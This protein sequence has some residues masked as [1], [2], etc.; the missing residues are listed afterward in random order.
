MLTMD[1]T[2]DTANPAAARARRLRAAA[3][4]HNKMAVQ[5]SDRSLKFFGASV[6]VFALACVLIKNESMMV[7]AAAS[8]IGSGV[9]FVLT[10]LN[11]HYSVW[12]SDEARNA[13]RKAVFAYDDAMDTSLEDMRLAMDFNRAQ[14]NAL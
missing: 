4:M 8:L 5:Y 14:H 13:N 9:L 7:V 10:A 11:I 1:E 2:M 3:R 12:H 6:L